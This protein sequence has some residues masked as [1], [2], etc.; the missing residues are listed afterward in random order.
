MT[1]IRRGAAETLPPMLELP[2]TI[3]G[4]PV[5]TDWLWWLVNVGYVLDSP[6]LWAEKHDILLLNVCSAAS[7][8]IVRVSTL[9]GV[10]NFYFCG[11]ELDKDDEPAPERLLDWKKDALANLG[12][13][14]VI[15]GVSI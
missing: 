2:E 8:R 6:L 14:S 4:R 3:L 10:L 15:R 11:Q 7:C 13:F 1:E 9:Y 12:R 5:P